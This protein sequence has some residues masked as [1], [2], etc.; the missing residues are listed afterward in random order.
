MKRYF[1]F[2]L[3]SILPVLIAPHTLRAQGGYDTGCGN[4]DAG[5]PGD[6]GSTDPEDKSGS[7]SVGDPIQP[8]KGNLHRDVTDI[9]VFGPA[10]FSFARNLNSRTTDFNDPY[11][12]LGYKQAWQHNWN[13]ETRQLTTKTYGFFDIKV[14]Y[15]DGNDQNFKAT[16]STGAQLAPPANI[17][18][19][20]YRWTGS[21][22]G[23]TL[24]RADGTEYDFWRYLSPKFHLTQVRNGLGYYWNCT[25][26]ANQQL[27]K[28]T[29]N[30]GRWIQIDHETGA[31]GVLRIYRV[32]TSDG[33]IVTYNYAPWASSGKFVLS[34]VNYPGGEHATYSYVTADPSSATARPLLAQAFDPKGHSGA[35]MKY[36]YNYNAISFGSVITGTVL[37][38]RNA[39]T[40]KVIATM[41]LGSGNYPEIL[42][43]DGSEAT[44]PQVTRKYSNGLLSEKRDAEGRGITF[45]RD[46]GGFGFIAGRAEVGTTAVINYT[47]DYAGRTLSRTNALGHTSSNSYNAKGFRLSHTDELGHT[48]AITRDTINSRPVRVDY[49]D[50]GHETWTYNASSQPLNHQLRSGGTESFAYDTSGNISSRTDPLGNATAYTY[51]PS[52]LI[53]SATD[54]LHNTTSFTYNWRGQVLTTTHPDSTSISYQYD[55][56]GNRTAAT[57]ELGHTTSYTYDEYNRL[58][59]A[60]DPL[61]RI[62]TYQYGQQPDSPDSAYMR[63]VSRVTL[64]SGKKTEYAYDRSGRRVSQTTGAGTADAAT[65]TYAYDV[66]DNMVAT[67]DPRGKTSTFTYDASHHCKTATDPLGHTTSWD[68]DSFGNKIAETRPDGGVTHFVYDSKN[69]LIQTTDPL[70]Q[71]TSQTYDSAGNLLMVTDARNNTYTYTYDS[72]NRKTAMIYPDGSHEN[73]SYDAVGNVLTFRTRAGQVKTSTYDNRNRET[74]ADWSDST[75]DVTTTYDAA[76]RALTMNSSVSALTYTYDGANE[77]TSEVQNI[78]GA[79]APATV[80]YGY[81]AD[82][83]RAS[84]VY[85]DGHAVAYGYSARNQV[86]NVSVDGA[87]ALASYGYDPD[88]NALSKVL[89]N[90]TSVVYNY[91]DADRLLTADNQKGGSSFLRYDYAYNSANNRTNRTE[92]IGGMTAVSSNDIYGYDAIDQL[93]QVKYS[94]NA[95]A[96]TQDRLVSYNYDATGDR[97]SLTDNGTATSYTVNN[98]NEY[99]AVGT[100]TPTYDAN[101]NLTLRGQASSS[102]TY[103][104]A[105]RLTCASDATGGNSTTFAYDARNRCVSRAVT[106]GNQQQT[107]TY[108]YFDG[109]NLI[110]ERDSSGAEIARY[111]HG[112]RTDEL[113]TR[114]ATAGTFYYHHDALGSTIALTDASGNPVERYSYDVYGAPTFKDGSGNIVSSSAS[115]NCFLFTGREYLSGTYLNLYDY[116]NRFYSPELGRFLQTD[117]IGFRAGDI[118]IYRYVGNGPINGIDPMGLCDEDNGPNSTPPMDRPGDDDG[119]D[120]SGGNPNGLTVGIG[121]NGSLYLSGTPPPEQETGANQIILTTTSYGIYFDVGTGQVGWYESQGTGTGPDSGLSLTGTLINGNASQFAGPYHNDNGGYDFLQGSLHFDPTGNFWGFSLGVGGPLPVSGSSTNTTT[122]TYPWFTLWWR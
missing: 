4:D 83:N 96:N 67:T 90:G 75:P 99:T 53:S 119:S 25:Y 15:A 37:E 113:L 66:V 72:R 88:G 10:S 103:D 20:L 89:E 82:G 34:S 49:A 86:S 108:Y 52:G 59:T 7:D 27:T 44:R 35:Q 78:A 46:S 85:P 120:T 19:R 36:S 100:T 87:P 13:Y 26:D 70:G 38:N 47:H 69:R 60:T 18:D 102:Y 107:T 114:T 105:N 115:G 74:L 29:N 11:W 21:T 57:D 42:E 56:F 30:F 109:W 31:D 98:L 95:G 118:N 2:F 111:V 9:A 112:G 24:V 122:V 23:Y 28:I 116:R 12:E 81:D 54:A 39:V 17:G 117:P 58:K 14:R 62:T 32:S 91:D 61:T 5:D 68:Y 3:I 92:T 76:S 6:T 50:G 43:G 8:H 106:S 63:K 77:L 73:W 16:D 45:T 40:D 121:V 65:T 48:T 80:A 84:L 104:A 94:Y 93:T 22:V 55:T 33:R 110:E 71:V 79:A 41:P 97:T 64:P 1:L 51:Y 101:G